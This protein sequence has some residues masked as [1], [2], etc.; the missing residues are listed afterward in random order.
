MKESTVK[1]TVGRLKAK[2]ADHNRD[3]EETLKL[4]DEGKMPT[5]Q[6]DRQL[7]N[8]RFAVKEYES[9]IAVYEGLVVNEDE[10]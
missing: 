8:L 9:A 6:A 7:L 3:I 5:W 4:A 1:K 10:L 2:I